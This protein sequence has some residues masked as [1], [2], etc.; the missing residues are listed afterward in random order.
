MGRHASGGSGRPRTP[1]ERA[2]SAAAAWA[3]RL[4]L[5]LV[6]GA[7]IWA[8]LQWAGIDDRT[9]LLGGA[10]AAVVVVVSAAVAATLAAPH[11]DDEDE[12]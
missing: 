6:T 12:R 5:G 11:R 7:A 8:V 1:R 10:G 4:A 2:T 3:Q 9:A